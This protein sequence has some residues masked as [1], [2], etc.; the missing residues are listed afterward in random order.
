M[1]TNK[2]WE[3]FDR[4]FSFQK[5]VIWHKECEKC[6]TMTGII[7]LVSYF[8]VVRMN[9]ALWFI[10]SYE[11]SHQPILVGNSF[12]IIF[13]INILFTSNNILGDFVFITS[14]HFRF[15][16][17]NWNHAEKSHIG[18][19]LFFTISNDIL[20]NTKGFFFVLMFYEA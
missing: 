1:S 17:I 11:I 3:L 12:Y 7:F 6:S 5:Y 14:L 4:T 20:H 2:R 16:S 15:L 8:P 13:T 18:L 19:D 9:L 10:Y